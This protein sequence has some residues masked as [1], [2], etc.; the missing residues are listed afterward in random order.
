[1]K[2]ILALTIIF[3]FAL[4]AGCAHI[5][6]DS[7]RTKAEGTAVGAAGGAA[8]GAAAGLIAGGGNWKKALVGAAIGAVI[9]AIAGYAYGDHVASKKKEYA[10]EED[11]LNACIAEAQKVQQETAQYNTALAGEIQTM[12]A[13]TDMLLERYA[14]RQ[15]EGQALESAK[16]KVDGK[17]KEAQEKLERVKFEVECQQKAVEQVSG[18]GQ[19]AQL[20]KLEQ[21]KAALQKELAQ[22]EAHTSSL[23]SLSSRMTV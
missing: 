5:Q 11:W 18:D 21:E 1:M 7:T 3:I 19:K 10:T 4:S 13:E 2:R 20:E 14:A 22:L 17:Q 15:V 16:E 8:V 9:G 23:A 12:Q 6:D